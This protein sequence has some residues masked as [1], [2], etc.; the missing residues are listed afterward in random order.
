MCARACRWVGREGLNGEGF[1][2]F[3]LFCFVYLIFCL[4][5]IFAFSCCKLFVFEVCPF[6]FLCL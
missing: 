5:L 2:F 3:F 4:F 1:F 6:S